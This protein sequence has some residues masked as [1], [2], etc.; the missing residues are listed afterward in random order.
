MTENEIAAQVVDAA[1]RVHRGLGPGLVESVYVTVLAGEL[2]KRGLFVETQLDIP[3]VYEGTYFERGFR[4]D[5]VA[6]NKVIIEVKSVEVIAP[7]HKKQLLTY[8]RLGDK[9]LGLLIN[10]NV[11]LIRDGITRIVNGLTE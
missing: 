10:F 11:R 2:R 8:L 5:L 3:I 4:A 9:R 6:E 7:L 1:L